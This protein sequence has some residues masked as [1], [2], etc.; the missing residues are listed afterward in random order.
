MTDSI[1][2]DPFDAYQPTR[3]E[4]AVMAAYGVAGAIR[5]TIRHARR[6]LFTMRPTYVP[7]AVAVLVV[8]PTAA[9]M[10][11][12]ATLP[13]VGG[14]MRMRGEMR[15]E[16]AGE[17]GAE[18]ARDL[19]TAAHAAAT[20]TARAA[21]GERMPFSPAVPPMAVAPAGD[22]DPP[23]WITPGVLAIW[24]DVVAAAHGVAEWYG[25]P[26]DAHVW[27]ALVT[28]ECPTGDGACES[29][30]GAFGPS[31]LMPETAA[32]IEAETGLRC[33]Q[34][35]PVDIPT[36][37]RCGAYYLAGRIRDN[38]W[39]WTVTD[40]EPAI[41]LGAIEYNDGRRT[42]YNAAA[43]AVK[44]G[45]DACAAIPRHLDPSI[46]CYHVQERWRA[47]LAER[48]TAPGGG[49]ELPQLEAMEVGR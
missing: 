5:S 25:V 39:A 40:E 30:A 9:A 35:N 37:L 31:Q 36:N 47:T 10:A 38:A 28:R 33:T 26:M 44:G 1:E 23:A 22:E 29:Y 16:A 21:I 14:G 24:P 34:R 3:R 32:A 4:R 19:A 2:G 15:V 8:T 20:A 18:R 12:W 43:A 27:G 17:A 48:G 45:G 42:G 49:Q 41:L 46:Y 6:A 11:T 13:G 7:L